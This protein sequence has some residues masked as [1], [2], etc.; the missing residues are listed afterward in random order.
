M[1]IIVTAELVSLLLCSQPSTPLSTTETANIRYSLPSKKCKTPHLELVSPASFSTPSCTST[2]TS[3][4]LKLY[5]K[6][7]HLLNIPWPWRCLSASVLGNTAIPQGLAP[8]LNFPVTTSADSWETV[9]CSLPALHSALT[10]FVVHIYPDVDLARMWVLEGRGCLIIAHVSRKLPAWYLEC[11][12]HLPSQWD[13]IH[14]QDPLCET[15]SQQTEDC[16]DAKNLSLD[17]SFTTALSFVKNDFVSFKKFMKFLKGE[18]ELLV[19][20]LP[21]KCHQIC[22]DKPIVLICN[23]QLPFACE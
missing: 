14:E 20:C 18:T 10:V 4:I 6:P 16:G 11:R 19:L 12:G 5:Q 15:G 21:A 23:L 3:S 22:L 7:H 17:W 1:T 2:G 13:Q 9:L 8:L